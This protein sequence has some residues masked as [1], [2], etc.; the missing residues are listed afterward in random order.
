MSYNFRSM[1]HWKRPESVPVPQVWRRFQ[2][3]KPMGK[4][5]KIPKFR[6]QDLTED[7]RETVVN[8]MLTFFLRDEPTCG[9]KGIKY[10]CHL[11]RVLSPPV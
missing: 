7:L 2:G 8:S 11:R 10:Y 9:N 4:N 1:G 6:V 5:N 3:K